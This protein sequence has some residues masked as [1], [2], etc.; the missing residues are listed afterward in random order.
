MVQPKNG[1]SIANH[2]MLRLRLRLQKLLCRIHQQRERVHCHIGLELFLTLVINTDG[3]LLEYLKILKNGLL[4]P[5]LL[6][7]WSLG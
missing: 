6:G 7:V 5:N 1:S 3:L 4:V 2:L